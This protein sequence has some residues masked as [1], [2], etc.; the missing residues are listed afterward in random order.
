MLPLVGGDGGSWTEPLL[1]VDVRSAERENVVS[2]AVPDVVFRRRS[3]DLELCPPSC[4]S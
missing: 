2:F 4:D 1:A 3:F